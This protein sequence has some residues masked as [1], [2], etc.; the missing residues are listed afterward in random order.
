MHSEK[1][2]RKLIFTI[3]AKFKLSVLIRDFFFTNYAG[4]CCPL[5]YI[6]EIVLKSASHKQK[7]LFVCT[8]RCFQCV[9]NTLHYIVM[10]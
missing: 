3:T 6:F 8:G 10:L 1:C 5:I 2:S 9:A 7:L 4:K